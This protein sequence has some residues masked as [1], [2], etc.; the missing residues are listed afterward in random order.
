[1]RAAEKENALPSST[2]VEKGSR[3]DV[4]CV[5]PIPSLSESMPPPPSRAP[6]QSISAPDVLPVPQA[7][8]IYVFK[9]SA[10][11]RDGKRKEYE[12]QASSESPHPRKFDIFAGEPLFRSR[13]AP[14]LK[15][16]SFD[17]KHR[18]AFLHRV[19]FLHVAMFFFAGYILDSLAKGT[20]RQRMT[21]ADI[22][23]W[24]RFVRERA[25]CLLSGAYNPLID[26]SW[27]SCAL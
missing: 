7:A 23:K 22:D 16:I 27:R 10:N 26:S 1:V 19:D 15:T 20:K 4:E 6:S 8:S 3:K 18:V 24:R 5:G 14:N 12:A 25:R 2:E 9:G 21:Q 11:Q 17:I 13:A